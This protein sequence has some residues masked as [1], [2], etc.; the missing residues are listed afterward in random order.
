MKRLF[1]MLLA[2]TLMVTIFVACDENNT[3]N[4]SSTTNTSDVS[5]VE[6]L[7]SEEQD[8]WGNTSLDVG[9]D[10]SATTSAN[11]SSDKDQ[12]FQPWVPLG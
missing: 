9:G 6:E 8:A 10:T 2:L 7:T 11:A 5:S 4:N 1:L 12:G 3:D